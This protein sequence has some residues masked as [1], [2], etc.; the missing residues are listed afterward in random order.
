MLIIFFDIKGIVYKEF[1][2]VGQSVLHTTAK[3]YGDCMKMCEGFAPNFGDKRTGC[4][5]ATMHRL[6]LPFSPWNFLT[7]TTLLSSPTDP[8]HLTWPPATFLC[9][10][11]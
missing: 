5:I 1:I 4:C 8:T 11:D 9:F 6:A 2:L 3:F 7:K 10:P